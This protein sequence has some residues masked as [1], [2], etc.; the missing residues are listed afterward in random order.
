MKSSSW[1]TIFS[2][3]DLSTPKQALKFSTLSLIPISVSHSTTPCDP[4][5]T[6]LSNSALNSSIAIFDLLNS[7]SKIPGL[8]FI[9]L[10]SPAT[11]SCNLAVE[12][13][14]AEP[15]NRHPSYPPLT[16]FDSGQQ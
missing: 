16:K 2:A 4:I 6:L 11:L 15:K 5:P 8:P 14:K 13:I 9:W 7:Y 12:I 3:P 1:Q 10:I